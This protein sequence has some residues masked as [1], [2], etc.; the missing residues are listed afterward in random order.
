MV[1]GISPF[2]FSIHICQVCSEGLAWSCPLGHV[3]GTHLRGRFMLFIPVSLLA[4]KLCLANICFTMFATYGIHFIEVFSPC[5]CMG[6][7]LSYN[8][9]KVAESKPADT[10]AT[11]QLPQP[12]TS[13]F[14][15]AL[16]S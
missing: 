15:A 1:A 11:V 3:K 4:T 12:L 10:A 13:A 8:K 2:H 5:V 9:R 7:N 16:H 14:T 6:C